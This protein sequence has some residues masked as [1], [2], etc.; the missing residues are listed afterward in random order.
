VTI[1]TFPC[2][3]IASGWSCAPASRVDVIAATAMAVATAETSSFMVSS[4][5]VIHPEWSF[6]AFRDII[7]VGHCP[8]VLP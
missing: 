2:N 3:G 6:T 8:E 7:P 5:A 1:T 4:V